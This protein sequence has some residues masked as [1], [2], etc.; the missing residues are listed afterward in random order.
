VRELRASPAV[1]LGGLARA[2]T[3]V[4]LL[5]R[6][7]AQPKASPRALGRARSDGIRLEDT[8]LHG[9]AHGALVH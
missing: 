5:R 4:A 9:C 1:G 6:L 2:I 3:H 7:A 8:L